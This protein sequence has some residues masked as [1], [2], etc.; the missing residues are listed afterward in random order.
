MKSI[1][2]I[3]SNSNSEI[4]NLPYKRPF[5]IEKIAKAIKCDGLID[6]I[7][8]KYID[9]KI[10]G[11]KEI[12]NISPNIS[13]NFQNN[14]NDE[15]YTPKKIKFHKYI[16]NERYP[17]SRNSM[18]SMKQNNKSNKIILPLIIR[19]KKINKSYNQ[20]KKE[21]NTL[22]STS[23]L[24]NGKKLNKHKIN[25]ISINALVCRKLLIDS[26]DYNSFH[27]NYNLYNENKKDY[28]IDLDL[29]Q[30][31]D[32]NKS[33]KNRRR[34]T[35]TGLLNILYHKYSRINGSENDTN[36]LTKITKNEK[37]NEESIDIYESLDIGKKSSQASEVNITNG[38]NA[39]VTMLRPTDNVN[40]S[41]I[42]KRDK[43]FFMKIKQ[44]NNK[45]IHNDKKININCL[46]SD[47]KK[48]LNRDKI[49]YKNTGKTIYEF[50]KDL[51]YK[52]LKKFEFLINKLFSKRKII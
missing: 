17:L 44:E 38:S 35:K 18:I 20:P 30:T 45:V 42:I 16:R 1:K 7:K 40:M 24:I 2:L 23:G 49:L 26:N 21:Q 5:S 39:F 46:F 48:M 52:R 33:N 6:S 10:K 29:K 32:V 25:K 37:S 41:K 9:P 28:K 36:E 27:D 19:N 12:N 11:R 8:Y 50:D 22:L 14:L 15:M 47:A 4:E 51:S 13:R 34:L 43:I 3:K 31:N